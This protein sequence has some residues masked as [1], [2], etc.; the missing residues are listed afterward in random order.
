M[1]YRPKKSALCRP[2]LTASHRPKRR[3]Y[4]LPQGTTKPLRNLF[5]TEISYIYNSV[6]TPKLGL[7]GIKIVFLRKNKKRTHYSQKQA[8]FI[9]VIYLL[10]IIFKRC[11]I[12]FYLEF[13]KSFFSFAITKFV[14]YS[15][16]YVTDTTVGR[17]IRETMKSSYRRKTLLGGIPPPATETPWI[18]PRPGFTYSN[19]KCP[20]E[21]LFLLVQVL[22]RQQRLRQ[23]AQ[24][25]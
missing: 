5:S 6:Y 3:E 15:Y 9:R 25:P 7:R 14:H 10:I 2:R 11:S 13:K 21:M 17:S 24:F 23:R 19:A 8:H 4:P 16:T 1:C 20:H 18:P 22:R 12:S